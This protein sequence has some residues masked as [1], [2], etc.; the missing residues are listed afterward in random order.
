[1]ALA[2]SRSK[3]S[4]GEQ[5]GPRVD[6]AVGVDRLQRAAQM[7]FEGMLADQRQ[8]GRD[9]LGGVA[10]DDLEVRQIVGRRQIVRRHDD[11]QVAETGI[12][13]QHREEGVDHARAET[14]AEHDAVDVADVEMLRRGLD[15]ERADH[16]GPLAER[17]RQRGIGAA[18]ADQQHGGVAGRID[19]ATAPSALP[20]P[21]GASRSHAATGRA[22]RHAAAPPAGRNCRCACEKGNGVV[23][24]AGSA[25][26]PRSAADRAGA[27][28]SALPAPPS[29]ASS[30][31]DGRQP[32]PRPVAPARRRAPRPPTRSRSPETAW[33]RRARRR[34]TAVSAVDT[35]RIG[36]CW[37]ILATRISA[38]LIESRES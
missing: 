3:A 15:R 12:L 38:H 36:P 30:V 6:Q 20:A 33:Q 37:D 27:P 10:G 16:A 5:A 13:R 25:D 34:R 9:H 24:Q 22:A 26:R 17:D 1:M 19:I 21:A 7:R 23:G 31:S 18:A 4:A 8:R 2:K 35:T 11:G 32:A 29:P 28:R 14:F